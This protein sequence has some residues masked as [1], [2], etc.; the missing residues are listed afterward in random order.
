MKPAEDNQLA[1]S[2]RS[3][4]AAPQQHLEKLRHPRAGGFGFSAVQVRSHLVHARAHGQD[5]VPQLGFGA[6]EGLAPVV[7]LDGGLQF[8]AGGVY[9]SRLSELFGSRGNHKGM[10]AKASVQHRVLFGH[11]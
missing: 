9:A 10:L 8:D 11:F 6:V 5:G 2:I 3:V 4:A 1:S 7:H